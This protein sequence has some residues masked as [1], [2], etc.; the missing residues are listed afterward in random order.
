MIILQKGSKMKL[1]N[2]YTFYVENLLKIKLNWV[3][4][5]VYV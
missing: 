3:L 4:I 1:I 5:N 2:E